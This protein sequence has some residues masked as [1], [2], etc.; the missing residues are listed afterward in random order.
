MVDVVLEARVDQP[1]VRRD[2]PIGLVAAVQV[3]AVAVEEDGEGQVEDVEVDAHEQ[4]EEEQRRGA[5]QVVPGLVSDHG[6]GRGVREVVVVLVNNLCWV[7][8]NYL[9]TEYL[10]LKGSFS[11]VS[12]PN[13]TR[14]YELESS[15]PDLQNALLCTL[16]SLL[17]NL[18]FFVK[19]DKNSQKKSRLNN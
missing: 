16:F 13:F 12:K 7:K 19:N 17:S 9:T 10:T 11:A 6:E 5:V 4:R 18:N 2:N 1:V 8:L 14:K 15:R 3:D